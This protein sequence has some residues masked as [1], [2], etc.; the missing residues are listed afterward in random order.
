MP[1][2]ARGRVRF[3]LAGQRAAAVSVFD[4]GGR[5]V[6]TLELDSRGKV[7]WIGTDQHG[8]R[9]AQGVYFYKAVAVEASARLVLTE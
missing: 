2:P 6:R 1:N 5:L 8:Q 7:S 4:A 3:S 9:C